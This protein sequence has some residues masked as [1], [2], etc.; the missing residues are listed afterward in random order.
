MIEAEE[1]LRRS[2]GDDAAGLEQNDVRSEEQGFAEIVGDEYDSLAETAGES[3]EFALELGARDR[4]ESAEGLVHQKNG[5]IGGE[6]TRDADA[7][8][9]AAGKFTGAAM[10]KLA[11]IEADEAEHFLDAGSDTSGVPIF[12]CGD[13]SDVFRDGEMRKEA[14]VLNDVSEMA[15]QANGVPFGGGAAFNEHLP[16][17]REKEPI[18]KL[19]KGGFATTA[20]AEEDQCFSGMNAEG[21]PGKNGGVLCRRNTIRNIAK[22][23]DRL[24]KHRNFRIHFD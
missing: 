5:G 1:L 15:A 20:A 19:E 10:G 16:C 9:L 21:Y 3:A 24:C 17:R 11:R 14:G 18:D 4:I 12:E 8:T 23:D 22:L 2:G 7:L 13:E 6:S